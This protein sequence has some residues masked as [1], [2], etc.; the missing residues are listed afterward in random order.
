MASSERANWF[1]ILWIVLGLVHASFF[2][3]GISGYSHFLYVF[4]FA[5]LFTFSFRYWLTEKV[6]GLQV[7][8]WAWWTGIGTGIACALA[9]GVF[10]ISLIW[11]FFCCYSGF[12]G[13]NFFGNLL[14][15]GFYPVFRASLL[16]FQEHRIPKFKNTAWLIE[17]LFGVI[18]V[19]LALGFLSLQEPAFGAF[20]TV[21]AVAISE[22]ITAHSLITI[23]QNE[24]KRKVEGL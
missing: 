23:K 21:V 5:S 22:L 8:G 12:L 17:N 13:S 20:L 1:G 14:F 19:W 3:W 10:W 24:E 4:G 15:F 11:L 6:L 7:E 9:T 18:L 16:W 2:L